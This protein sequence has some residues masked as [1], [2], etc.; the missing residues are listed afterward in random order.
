MSA[1]RQIVVSLD[2]QTLILME[3][4]VCVRTYSV[5]TAIKGMGFTSGSYRTPTG[6]F[7]IIEAIGAGHASGTIF[8]GRVPVGI[9]Q[10]GDATNDDLVLTRILR[11]D[12]MNYANANTLERCIY[13]HGTNQEKRIGR[14][15]SHGC[16]RL[17]NEDMIDLFD[18]VEV[19]DL[20][21][22]EPISCPRGGLLFVHLDHLLNVTDC[23]LAMKHS[24]SGGGVN[25][26]LTEFH[27]DSRVSCAIGQINAAKNSGYLPVLLTHF[28]P[29]L[30]ALMSHVLEID[31]FEAT[32][33]SSTFG[34]ECQHLGL[35]HD[36]A[37]II[38]DWRQAL[39]PLRVVWIG[40][41]AMSSDIHNLVDDMINIEM[42]GACQKLSFMPLD[43]FID[44]DESRA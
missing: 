44:M 30:A 37:N 31:H 32:S 33:P 36:F 40:H 29:Q 35:T 8:K 7:R 13:I 24:Q 27:K 9:W 5:S 38:S 25:D 14:P 6:S 4:E 12:G 10:R 26:V 41:G 1:S 22:I 18:R 3:N 19:N 20:V 34:A 23:Q 28:S 39:L 11:L 43:P 17:K 2:R 15:A 16:V 42:H 21:Q